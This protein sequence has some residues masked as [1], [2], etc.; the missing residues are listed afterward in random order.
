MVTG[1]CAAASMTA[2][3]VPHAPAPMTPIWSVTR[4]LLLDRDLLPLGGLLCWH[5]V[6]LLDPVVEVAARGH[7]LLA[8]GCLHVLARL[9]R[10]EVSHHGPERRLDPLSPAAAAPT[11]RVQTALEVPDPRLQLIGPCSVIH[12]CHLHCCHCPHCC[13]AA[14]PRNGSSA[15]GHRTWRPASGRRATHAAGPGSAAS[16]RRQ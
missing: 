7:Q 15:H 11:A 13:R 6:H 9:V 14:A 5:L 12:A 1:R 3:V 8:A 4:R 16:C 2:R 10:E